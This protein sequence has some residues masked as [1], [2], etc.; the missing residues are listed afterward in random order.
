MTGV[1][2]HTM[3]FLQLQLLVISHLQEVPEPAVI[4]SSLLIGTV[5][6]TPK[7]QGSMFDITFLSAF[8]SIGCLCIVGASAR[9]GR[10]Q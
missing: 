7:I 6:M 8:V 4:A 3:I 9:S 1:S 10:Q 5:H 2:G